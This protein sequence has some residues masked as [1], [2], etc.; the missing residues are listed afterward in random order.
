MPNIDERIQKN[1]M[2]MQGKVGYLQAIND[3]MDLILINK[4]DVYHISK[5]AYRPIEEN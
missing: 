1:L 3:V 5:L 2:N 4:C